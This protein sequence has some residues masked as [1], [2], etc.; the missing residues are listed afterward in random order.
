M[1]HS[2]QSSSPR[3]CTPRGG[4]RAAIPG[5]PTVGLLVG[6]LV[7]GTVGVGAAVA[8]APATAPVA[9]SGVTAARATSAQPAA[10]LSASAAVAPA[11]TSTGVVGPGTSSD[12]TSQPSA[13]PAATVLRSVASAV[14][15]APKV[16]LHS[17]LQNSQMKLSRAAL[18]SK[19]EVA[20]LAVGTTQAVVDSSGKTWSADR[21]YV[22]GS[23]WGPAGS[24]VAN[25]TSDR[26][27]QSHRWG[28][29]GY[30]VKVPSA[31]TYRV[32]L[33]FA[34]MVF[35][36]TGKRVFDVSAEGSTKLS[37][38]DAVAVAGARTAVVRT[39]DVVV[40][41][42]N[43]DL[44]FGRVVEDPMLS[45][46][47]VTRVSGGVTAPAPARPPHRPQ[48]R[49]RP[50]PQHRHRPPPRHPHP[51]PPPPRHRPRHRL[52]PRPRPRPRPPVSRTPRTRACRPVCR[53]VR[54]VR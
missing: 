50:P 21:S 54:P 12:P 25:T 16:R 47:L 14:G 41:D 18:S 26:L 44:D 36:T 23:A 22:G 27:Y 3:H 42:G 32:Q 30:D 15:A 40:T 53:C 38:F 28:M 35:D 11:A 2:P 4:A 8:G 33:H 19:V 48:H 5:L 31:G 45:G 17:P 51:H 52:R 10:A 39:F 7:L 34:E 1:S 37:R 9:E 20:R 29:S 24:A 49:H 13:S 46:L 6:A 43:L